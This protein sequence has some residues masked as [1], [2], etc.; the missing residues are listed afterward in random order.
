MK[1]VLLSILI[2]IIYGH[3]F[4]VINLKLNKY[5]DTYF[6]QS[7]EILSWINY[8]FEKREIINNFKLDLSKTTNKFYEILINDYNI[9]TQNN[10]LF[11][12]N[13]RFNETLNTETYYN[14][15][16]FNKIY[17]LTNSYKN[18]SQF[19]INKYLWQSITPFTLNNIEGNITLE[20]NF[21]SNNLIH[22]KFGNLK[23]ST[24]ADIITIKDIYDQI[25]ESEWIIENCT[26]SNNIFNIDLSVIITIV[27]LSLIF[28][29]LLIIILIPFIKCHNY[30]RKNG[31]F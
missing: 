3:N 6:Q 13:N 27:L 1:T 11:Y 30:K 17:Y 12:S 31:S 20:F 24:S 19:E 18:T 4:N 5:N 22:Y 9:Y 21:N 7:D 10:S 23:I 2:N 16:K 28:I 8:N 29:V 15:F 25:I 26:S 14:C